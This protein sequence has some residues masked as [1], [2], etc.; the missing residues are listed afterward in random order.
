[1]PLRVKS[2]GYCTQVSRERRASAARPVRCQPL[3]AQRAR[4]ARER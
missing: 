4:R 3:H 1:M 2:R